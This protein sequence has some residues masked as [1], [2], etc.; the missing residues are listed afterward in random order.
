[1]RTVRQIH[2]RGVKVPP[3]NPPKTRER[4]S[5][6]KSCR[7]IAL[8]YLSCQAQQCPIRI[9]LLGSWHRPGVDTHSLTTSDSSLIFSKN[10]HLHSRHH[11]LIS[12]ICLS[13]G[14]GIF[15]VYVL[16]PSLYFNRLQNQC[17]FYL[18]ILPTT[19]GYSLIAG[20]I[21]TIDRYKRESGLRHSENKKAKI[22]KYCFRLTSYA[23]S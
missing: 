19:K 1:M 12:G 7:T 11:I 18:A 13:P 4:A 15:R 2:S 20:S 8:E 14:P 23:S 5:Y 9:S 6:T 22:L 10:K 3:T 16:C 21:M 17:Y